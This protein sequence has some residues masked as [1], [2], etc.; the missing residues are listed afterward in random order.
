MLCLVLTGPLWR[1][2]IS[3]EALRAFSL[4]AI[5]RAAANAMVSVSPGVVAD[6]PSRPSRRCSYIKAEHTVA[7]W[8][9]RRLL[10][11]ERMVGGQRH[12]NTLRYSTCSFDYYS[13]SDKG[14]LI[15]EHDRYTSNISR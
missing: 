4:G 12:V 1:M 9:Q 5:M 11:V 2:G 10:Y 14:R 13:G 15:N 8:R 6:P 7:E 3:C